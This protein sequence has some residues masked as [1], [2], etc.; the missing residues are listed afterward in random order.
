VAKKKVD[1]SEVVQIDWRKLIPI[2]IGLA[3]GFGVAVL[4]IKIFG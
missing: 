3:F 1:M 2:V 4:L